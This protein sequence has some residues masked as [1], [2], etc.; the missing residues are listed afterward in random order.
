MWL[1]FFNPERPSRLQE[2]ER[3]EATSLVMDMMIVI[4]MQLLKMA[5]HNNTHSSSFCIIYDT[6]DT[7]WGHDTIY[8]AA[9]LV[10]SMA[11][12]INDD[13]WRWCQAWG[14]RRLGTVVC[15][16][17]KSGSIKNESK[18]FTIFFPGLGHKNQSRRQTAADRIQ[19]GLFF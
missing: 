14:C 5:G 16:V 2:L 3:A 19:N 9:S 17:S 8:F 11:W 6:Y 15:F 4:W 10:T 13:G 7:R 1:L 12:Q 18:D